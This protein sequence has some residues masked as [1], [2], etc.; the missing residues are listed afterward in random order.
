MQIEQELAELSPREDMM[1]TVGVFDGVHLGHKYLIS[2]LKVLAWQRNLLS[3]VVTFR[4]HPQSVMSPQ[5]ELSYLVDLNRKITLLKDEGVKVVIPVSFTAELAQLSAR[6][7]ISMLKKHLGMQGLVIGHDFALGQSREGN[8]TALRALGQEMNFT[9]NM[10]T[11]V[12]I[13]GEVVSSTAIRDAL[14]SGDMKRVHKLLGYFFSLQGQVVTGTG[15]GIELGFPTA[16]LAINSGQAIPS[17]GVYATWAYIDDH[18][19]PSMTNIGLCPTFGGGERTIEVYVLD[20]HG[21]LY[22]QELKID[23]IERLRDEKKFD[24]TEELKKQIAVDIEEG[25]AVLQPYGRN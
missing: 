25:R 10:M 9:V 1:L 20:Y 12:M 14:A 19:Y 11:P 21:D 7:F 2:R 18:V 8:N 23:I 15:R 5:N 24:N 16:N 22:E 13:D 17:D 3:G 6:Q 4:Q